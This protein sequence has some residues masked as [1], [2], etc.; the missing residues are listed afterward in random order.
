MA[1]SSTCLRARSAAVQA[2]YTRPRVRSE[3]CFQFLCARFDD[4]PGPLAATGNGSAVGGAA[5]GR[6][7]AP[8][9]RLPGPWCAPRPCLPASCAHLVFCPH[10]P[11]ARAGA[12]AVV[13]T[14][15]PGRGAA[16]GVERERA[17][18]PARMP[19][20]APMANPLPRAD[21]ASP[22]RHALCCGCADVD[23]GCHQELRECRPPC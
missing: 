9:E 20:T 15:G 21:M 3:R 18:A 7:P 23:Q 13:R 11:W 17:Q 2:A 6:R 8:L 10:G 14:N 22:R 5:G 19:A 4:L 1:G 12:P 16:G